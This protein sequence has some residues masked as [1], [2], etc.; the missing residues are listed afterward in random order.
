MDAALTTVAVTAGTT[1]ITLTVTAVWQRARSAV[2]ALSGRMRGEGADAADGDTTGPAGSAR[3]LPARLPE[4]RSLPARPS[5]TGP[6]PGRL[7]EVG[8]ER[9]AETGP[10]NGSVRSR[11]AVAGPVY[12]HHSHAFGDQAAN[13]AVSEFSWWQESVR[14]PRVENP[15]RVFRGREDLLAELTAAAYIPGAPHVLHG[16]GGSGKTA[17]AAEVFLAAEA[18]GLTALWVVAADRTVLR[19]G[20]LT[21]AA[22]LG[23]EQA[24]L[25]GAQDGRLAAAD[26]VWKYLSRAQRWFLV[27]DKADNPEILDGW[28]RSSRTGAI[29]VTTRRARA[30]QWQKAVLHPLDVL[31]SEDAARVITDFAPGRGTPQD[32]LDL[33]NRLGR[34]P[35]ALRLAGSYL[36]RQ[37]LETWSLNDYRAR[38]ERD[39]TVLADQGAE[40]PL[41]ED[42]GTPVAEGELRQ[43][44]SWT[45][46][47]T[48]DALSARGLPEATTLMRLLSCWSQAPLPRATLSGLSGG[49]ATGVEAGAQPLAQLP[50]ERGAEARRG[51]RTESGTESGRGSGTGSGTEFGRGSATESATGQGFGNRAEPALRA[52]IDNSLV[53][54]QSHAEPSADARTTPCLQVHGL[55]LESVHAGIE[56]AERPWYM[57]TAAQLLDAALPGGSSP[58][59][60]G[61]LRLLLP[62]I[63]AILRH[64]DVR[65]SRQSVALGIRAAQLSCEAGDYRTAVEMATLTGE[66]SERLQ[67]A[68]HHDT[69]TAHHHQGDYLRRLGAYHEAEE[70][71]RRV[72]AR[73][74]DTLGARHRETLET[75]AALS[76]TLYLMG[77]SEESLTWIR[78]AIAGQRRTLGNDHVETLRS[79][80]YALELLAHSGR[81]ETFLRDGPATITDAERSLGAD[82]VVTAIAYSNYAYGL[83]RT[84]APAE[85]KVAAAERALQAR[86]RLYGDGHP[87]VHSAKLVLSWAQSLAGAHESALALM[88]EAVDGRERLLGASHPLTIKARV[89]YAER[90]AEADHPAQAAQLLRDNLPQ[91]EAIY[92]PH[93]LD[94]QRAT[95]LQHRLPTP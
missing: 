5:E 69:M 13:S 93:D 90:L 72:Y 8:A 15:P 61:R 22:E 38:F 55:V 68:D 52:L 40:L 36:E 51:S 80:A 42:A 12:R 31:P 58:A 30:P 82:H 92:G 89:L 60:A 87:T 10:E 71:L 29:L 75:A 17:L 83:L 1:L 32:A 65:T 41:I 9:G 35:L 24:E 78:R 47:I 21:V 37:A 67:G 4:A 63:T 16:M 33:A 6:F 46:Q 50:T 25:L 94:V 66:V 81:T 76:I 59:D 34:L 54:A 74:T 44:L 88:R 57:R 11:A 45:W 14:T 91:A 95:D 3:R 64:T 43:R 39:G 28:L 19:R 77:H 18:E 70:V 73:R 7:S 23:A 48:L 86:V 27:I 56:A 20:M 84:E 26:L 53:S 49:P 2:A 79:R 85:D 62:H